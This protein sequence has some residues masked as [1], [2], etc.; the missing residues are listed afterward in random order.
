M[1]TRNGLLLKFVTWSLGN[2]SVCFS[3][4]NFFKSGAAIDFK[5]KNQRRGFS[6]LFLKLACMEFLEYLLY[7]VLFLRSSISIFG[8]PDINNSNSC[9]LNIDISCLGIIS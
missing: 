7:S 4:Y 2:A 5:I 9:S 1:V 6:W 8:N 3:L